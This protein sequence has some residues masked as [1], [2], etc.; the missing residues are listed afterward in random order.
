MKKITVLIT[1]GLL[2][3]LIS[4]GKDYKKFKGTY[5]LTSKIDSADNREMKYKIDEDRGNIGI[6]IN[7]EGEKLTATTVIIKGEKSIE[8]KKQSKVLPL[9]ETDNGIFQYKNKTKDVVLT[10]YFND[11]GMKIAEYQRQKNYSMKKESEKF[12]KKIR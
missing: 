7:Q 1:V 11:E 8:P 9:V 2:S 12:F 6:T 4:C 3:T 10:F 5:M